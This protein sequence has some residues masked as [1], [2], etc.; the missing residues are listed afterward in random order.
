[1]SLK[2]AARVH[3]LASGP[4]LSKGPPGGGEDGPVSLGRWPG[5]GH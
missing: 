2:C 4:A 3:V 5:A 1:M